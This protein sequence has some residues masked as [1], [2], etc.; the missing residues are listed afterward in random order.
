M[1]TLIKKWFKRRK[2]RREA[3]KLF[4]SGPGKTREYFAKLG[5]R[6]D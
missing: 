3:A 6:V 4:M 5:I 1:I 2:M